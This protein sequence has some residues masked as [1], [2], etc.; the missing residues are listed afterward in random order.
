MHAP[1]LST[2][3]AQR[4]DLGLTILRIVLGIVFVMHGGQKL[5]VFGL[6]G[7]AG[8]F[9]QMGVP[10]PG[11]TGPL[12]ALVEF[13]GGL[14]LVFGLL[15]RLAAVGLIVVMLGAIAMVHIAAGFFAPNG[16]EFPLTLIAGLAAIV[17]IG[18]GRFSLDS[19]IDARRS[20]GRAVA[21]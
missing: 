13:F 4:L 1:T 10:A 3:S 19:L 2:Y 6:D 12:T 5:F 21:A 14:A 9:A 16:F 15:S 7:V 8:G 20:G 17:L 18:P 11:L